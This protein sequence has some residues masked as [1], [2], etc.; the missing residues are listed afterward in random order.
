MPPL[1]KASPVVKKKNYAVDY[2]TNDAEWEECDE[3]DADEWR[4]AI[5]TAEDTLPSE[6]EAFEHWDSYDAMK[7]SD[8]TLGRIF[9]ETVR[10]KCRA[11]TKAR[12]AVAVE[13]VAPLKESRISMDASKLIPHFVVGRDEKME[14]NKLFDEHKEGEHAAIVAKTKLQIESLLR[15]IEDALET[16]SDELRLD[17]NASSCT[18]SPVKNSGG[19][20]PTISREGTRRDGCSHIRGRREDFDG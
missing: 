8:A 15:R 19:E 16:A 7:T 14:V 9:G 2:P 5:S 17:V 13:C 11:A 1:P 6:G 12:V 18:H 4:A 10:L 3:F 20:R